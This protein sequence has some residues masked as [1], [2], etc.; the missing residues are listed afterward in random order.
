MIGCEFTILARFWNYINYI[1][2]IIDI[3]FNEYL[4]G[5]FEKGSISHHYYSLYILE[6]A[7]IL[8]LKWKVIII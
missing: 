8:Q 4:I 7:E 1:S 2:Q 3:P 6:D 5:S